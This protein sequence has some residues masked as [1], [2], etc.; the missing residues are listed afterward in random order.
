MFAGLWN[1]IRSSFTPILWGLTLALWM[2]PFLPY[3]LPGT[4]TLF[5]TLPWLHPLLSVSLLFG[6]WY[7][8][9][10]PQHHHAH[11]SQHVIDTYFLGGDLYDTDALSQ[12]YQWLI[13]DFAMH[14]AAAWLRFFS[15]DTYDL[16]AVAYL[17]PPTQAPD[18]LTEQ[19][20]VEHPDT[21]P[22]CDTIPPDLATQLDQ[23][24]LEQFTPDT[25]TPPGFFYFKPKEST[26]P[27]HTSH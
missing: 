27:H 14:E 15:N 7:H 18:Q 26:T 20:L 16:F 10:T 5:T 13:H 19:Q 17:R 24:N 21:I 8:I 12:E 4:T 6:L 3:R 2:F 11:Y 22:G 1:R 9:Q 25:T 23:Y